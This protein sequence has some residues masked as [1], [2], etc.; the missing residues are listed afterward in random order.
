MNFTTCY[1]MDWIQQTTQYCML[2][3]NKSYQYWIIKYLRR[4]YKASICAWYDC[5][6][7]SL[8]IILIMHN[9]KYGM[10]IVRIHVKIINFP[11]DLLF[12]WNI[13]IKNSLLN[14]ARTGLWPARDWFLE[15]AFVRDVS[16]LACMCVCLPPRLLITSGVIWCDIEPLWLVKQV[17]GVSLSF[18]WQLKS[19]RIV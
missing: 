13:I 19:K 5:R 2:A 18:I 4:R 8:V 16:M 9:Y 12:R 7:K 10:E 15:I 1:N 3:S 6:D 17:L 14:Q 11:I